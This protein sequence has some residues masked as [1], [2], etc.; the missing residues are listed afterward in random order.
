LSW[1]GSSGER[2]EQGKGGGDSRETAEKKILAAEPEKRDKPGDWGF[3][4]IQDGEKGEGVKRNPERQELNLLKN[5]HGGRKS[6]N[7]KKNFGSK[8][9]G[10]LRECDDRIDRGTD[11]LFKMNR[12]T[13]RCIG[14]AS[15]MERKAKEGFMFYFADGANLWGEAMVGRVQQPRL[16]VSDIGWMEKTT[17]MLR[18]QSQKREKEKGGRHRGELV[19]IA[20]MRKDYFATVRGEEVLVYHGKKGTREKIMIGRYRGGGT[21]ETTLGAEVAACAGIMKEGGLPLPA[22]GKS[23]FHGPDQERG[24]NPREKKAPSTTFLRISI[25]HDTENPINRIKRVV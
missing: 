2:V 3:G 9:G 17:I 21:S 10:L 22:E 13:T 4:K 5:E 24:N 20:K 19:P 15:W 23:A 7:T 14:K 12:T 6:K 16:G 18:P 25:V 1:L 11:F 8:A